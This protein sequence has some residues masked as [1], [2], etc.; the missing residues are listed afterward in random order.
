[1]R[2][3]PRKCNAIQCGKLMFN[4]GVVVGSIISSENGKQPVSSVGWFVISMNGG[5]LV[6][7]VHA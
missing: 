3:L 5:R 4:D 7:V 6:A 1:M 2:E